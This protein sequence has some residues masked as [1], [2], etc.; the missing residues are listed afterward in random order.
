MTINFNEPWDGTMFIFFNKKHLIVEAQPS[1][2]VIKGYNITFKINNEVFDDGLQS[3][4][5]Q[6]LRRI[7]KYVFK[8][9]QWI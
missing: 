6:S 8:L 2:K 3:Y 1:K 9:N 5:K 4:T 7:N